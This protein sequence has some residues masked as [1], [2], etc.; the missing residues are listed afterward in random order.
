MTNIRLLISLFFIFSSSLVFAAEDIPILKL[1]KKENIFIVGQRA[2]VAVNSKF[3]IYEDNK[4]VALGEFVRCNKNLCL[5]QVKKKT[6]MFQLNET[7]R[8][9]LTPRQAPKKVIEKKPAPVVASPKVSQP[10][11][12]YNHSVAA[13]YGGPLTSAISGNYILSKDKLSYYAGLGMLSGT[14]SDVKLSGYGVT[15]GASYQ[16]HQTG[17]LKFLAK[18]L[19]DIYSADLDF[20]VSRTPFEENVL[21]FNGQFLQTFEY[22]FSDSFSLGL[23]IGYALNTLEKDYT[24]SL[25]DTLSISFSGG[26]IQTNFFARYFF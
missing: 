7:Q 12:S 24:N 18:F 2:G 16:Y 15:A 23:D 10:R 4:L 20:T 3:Y 22:Q 21:F 14:V 5:G 1:T 17:N 9:S 8:L 6:K 19:L 26:L 25:G 13:Q 11:S